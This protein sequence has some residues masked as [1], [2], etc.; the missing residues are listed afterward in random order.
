MFQNCGKMIQR[1]SIFVFAVGMI[2]TI[3]LAIAF[4]KDSWG[5]FDFL[6]FIAI[7]DGGGFITYVNSLFLNGFGLIVENNEAQKYMLE[8]PIMESSADREKEILDEGGWK[9]VCGRVNQNY[10]SSCACGKSRGEG[11]VKD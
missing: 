11:A 6:R 3:I 8:T 1:I 10:V 7:L 9:C 5:K 4:G 2:A